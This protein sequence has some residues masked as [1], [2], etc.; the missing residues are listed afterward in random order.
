MANLI[1]DGGGVGWG[2][3][4]LQRKVPWLT[5]TKM[6]LKKTHPQKN[7]SGDEEDHEIWGCQVS[8]LKLAGSVV[9]YLFTLIHW[10]RMANRPF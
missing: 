6:G 9:G 1:F 4:K 3:E 10:T 7:K 8:K 5:K 2:V